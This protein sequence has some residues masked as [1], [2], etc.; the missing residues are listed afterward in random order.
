MNKRYLISLIF[1]IALGFIN[2]AVAQA[3]IKDSATEEAQIIM[4]VQNL[5]S[6]IAS[7]HGLKNGEF[8][9]TFGF[10]INKLFS[11]PTG[12]QVKDVK[13]NYYKKE[14]FSYIEYS[15]AEGDLATTVAKDADGNLVEISYLNSMLS[16]FEI[17]RIIV[18]FDYTNNNTTVKLKI[19]T[20]WGKVKNETFLLFKRGEN[21]PLRHE[22]SFN[23]YS[24]SELKEELNSLFKQAVNQH[25]LST[26][27]KDLGFLGLMLNFI[28]V[29]LPN[30]GVTN[31][32]VIILSGQRIQGIPP[33]NLQADCYLI[34]EVSSLNVLRRSNGRIEKMYRFQRS[35]KE[36]KIS[37]YTVGFRSDG[38]YVYLKIYDI[39]KQKITFQKKYYTPLMTVQPENLFKK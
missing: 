5:K 32:D 7:L 29:G 26:E 38:T 19:N 1:F 12:F 4:E 10:I 23:I 33:Q 15:L 14:E 28:I 16:P 21:T 11:L 20:L 17:R 35:S 13:I 3:E 31:K 36:N 22:S 39:K 2:L 9:G 34:D 30:H 25:G 6:K 37:I 24:T 8:A 18:D 27:T